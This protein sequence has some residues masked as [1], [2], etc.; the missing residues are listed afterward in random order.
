M[1]GARALFAAGIIILCGAETGCMGGR[2]KAPPY[3]LPNVSKDGSAIAT[4]GPVTLTTAEIE[5]RIREQSAFIKAQLASPEKRKKFVETQVRMELLA[6]EGWKKGL[7]EDPQ[8]LEDLK[9][10]IVTRMMREVQG[11]QA[12]VEVSEHELEAA[13][14]EREAEY[15]KPEKI[16]LS[17]I[18]LDA[19]DDGSRKNAKKRLET[20][21]ADIEREEKNKNERAFEEAAKRISE[22]PDAKTT[23][24][25]LQFSSRNELTARFGEKNAAALFDDVELGR[26]AILET[27]KS[28]I[29]F[30]KTG[31][32]RP[33]VRTLEMVK[34]QLSAEL[35]QEK[36]TKVFDEKMTELEKKSGVLI[37]ERA[38]ES[39]KVDR[40]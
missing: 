8:I 33:V 18:V 31:K 9:R 2:E 35:I 14:K 23:G 20:L 10:A 1:L 36:K 34:P 19:S 25:D 16:R 26:L 4:I 32:R 27:P 3:P 28:I 29:L 37:D 17:E 12:Q 22:D 6:Q 11:G 13:F 5:K 40:P 38:L 30:K 21:K 15:N 24:G 39:L 7:Y